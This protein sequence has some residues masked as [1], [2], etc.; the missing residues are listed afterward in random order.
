MSKNSG[1]GD[2]SGFGIFILGIALIGG[3]FYGL[4]KLIKMICELISKAWAEHKAKKAA[5][6]KSQAR[7]QMA[8]GTRAESPVVDAA[9]PVAVAK[10]A[11]KPAARESAPVRSSGLGFDG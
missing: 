6:A 10:P 8:A 1:G 5:L 11:E 2:D 4:Y 7:M 9:K 3:I